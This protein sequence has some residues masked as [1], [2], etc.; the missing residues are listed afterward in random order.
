MNAFAE[1]WV[2]SVKTECLDKM[3]LFGRGHL[4]RVPEVSYYFA[5]TDWVLAV[6]PLRGAPPL[7]R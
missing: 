3:I 2:K 7:R 6:A 4:E 5:W 1:R